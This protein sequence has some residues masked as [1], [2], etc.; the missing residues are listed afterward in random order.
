MYRTA[1]VLMASRQ[2]ISELIYICT[3]YKY[4]EYGDLEEEDNYK[5][6]N[7]IHIGAVSILDIIVCKCDHVSVFTDVFFFMMY[8]VVKAINL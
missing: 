8:S 4:R 6:K 1:C 5:K 3:R 7:I 2:S